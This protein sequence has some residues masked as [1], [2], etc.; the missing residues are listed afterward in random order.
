MTKGEE[1]ELLEG[2]EG[3][4]SLHVGEGDRHDKLGEKVEH[5]QDG[6]VATGRSGECGLAADKV[7]GDNVVLFACAE[8][9]Q[10]V[11]RATGSSLEGQASGA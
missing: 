4:F 2:E 6:A 10:G 11:M 3:G 1:P 9:I 5:H 7:K 8:G